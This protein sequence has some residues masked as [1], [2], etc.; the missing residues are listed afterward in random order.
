VRKL[1]TRRGAAGHK[2]GAKAT[3]CDRGHAHPSKKEARRCAQLHLL[4]RAGQISELQYE[5]QFWFELNDAVLKHDNGRRV[6]FRP[7]FGYVEGGRKVAEDVKSSATRT[8][9]YV[10]RS[11]IFRALFPEWELREL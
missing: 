10:L 2:Y 5:P 6:G 4:E 3:T 11:V 7:D 1:P 8:E 9:A